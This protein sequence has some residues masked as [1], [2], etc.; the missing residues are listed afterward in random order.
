MP[1]LCLT[2]VTQAERHQSPGLLFNIPPMGPLGFGELGLGCPL[3]SQALFTPS[4]VGLPSAPG[5]PHTHS[6][7]LFIQTSK[8][9]L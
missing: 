9:Y 4:H 6:A 7:A 1:S 8:V 2:L 5:P 3:L